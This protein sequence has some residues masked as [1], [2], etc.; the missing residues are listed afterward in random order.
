MRVWL[1]EHRTTI[2]R[3]VVRVAW[4][5]VLWLVLVEGDLHH[6]ILAITVVLGAAAMGVRTGIGVGWRLSG[7][8]LL[9]FIPFF[10]RASFVGALD[11]AGR[12]FRGRRALDPELLTT[13]LRLPIDGPS[14]VFFAD[15]LCL[16]PGT[17]CVGLQGKDV[18]IHVI[19][20]RQDQAERTAELER[21]VA[22]LFGVTLEARGDP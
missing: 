1:A 17:L 8:G 3:L 9:R 13:R 18:T 21:R 20:R 10:I 6:P 4:F 11:V 16:I 12:A 22:D 7:R 5:G 19:D 14:R 15:V 2:E